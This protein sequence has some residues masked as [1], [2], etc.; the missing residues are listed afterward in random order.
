MG[1]QEWVLMS[2]NFERGEVQ[3][4]S[5]L[6]SKNLMEEEEIWWIRTFVGIG[7]SLRFELETLNSFSDN[8]VTKRLTK[9]SR[10]QNS[11]IEPL[12]LK[13]FFLFP[14][15]LGVDEID[16]VWNKI[17]IYNLVRLVTSNNI[18]NLH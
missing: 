15:N 1:D 18:A 16:L 7:S 10:K 3:V 13:L 17:E 2:G 11:L 8:I 9:S 14:S 5:L 6:R 12:T 4:Y